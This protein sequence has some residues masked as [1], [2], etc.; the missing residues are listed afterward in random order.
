MKTAIITSFLI[1]FSMTLCAQAV[2]EV[3]E[4][5]GKAVVVQTITQEI[6]STSAELDKEIQ[7]IEQ[8]IESLTKQ[9]VILLDLLRKVRAIEDKNKPEKPAA[10]PDKKQ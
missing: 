3:K 6:P 8:Q 5:D 4:V 10:V 1:F 7:K 9:K 2:H